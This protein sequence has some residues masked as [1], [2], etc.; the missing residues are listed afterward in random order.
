MKKLQYNLK[1]DIVTLITLEPNHPSNRSFRLNLRNF[2]I[3]FHFLTNRARWTSIVDQVILF[4]C[5]T[6]NVKL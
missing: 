2:Y 5:L 3:S 1:F 6:Q 4:F